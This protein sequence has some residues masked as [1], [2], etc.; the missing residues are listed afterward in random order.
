L[1]ERELADEN[2]RLFPIDRDILHDSMR[3]ELLN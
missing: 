3:R 1:R 2:Q